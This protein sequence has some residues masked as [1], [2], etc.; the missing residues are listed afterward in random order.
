MVMESETQRYVKQDGTVQGHDFYRLRLFVVLKK[1]YA[2]G[3]SETEV[4]F[5]VA[6]VHQKSLLDP[7]KTIFIT[8]YLHLI[9]LNRNNSACITNKAL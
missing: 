5:K 6:A 8:I 2:D 7:R 3:S 1:L 4:S 9:D